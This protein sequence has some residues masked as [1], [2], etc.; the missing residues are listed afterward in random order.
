MS[1][2]RNLALKILIAAG[3]LCLPA[4]ALEVTLRLV[5]AEAPEQPVSS[6]V[7]QIDVDAEREQAQAERDRIAERAK[8]LNL[9]PVKENEAKPKAEFD[10]YVNYMRGILIDGK[11]PFQRTYQ[12]SYLGRSDEIKLSLDDGEHVIDPGA[13]RFT[14]A[15]ATITTTDPTLRV[16]GSRI[17]VLAFPVS[18][19]AVDGSA[20]RALPA[21]LR[22]LPVMPRLYW[23]KED[24]LP[25]EKL[26]ASNA[27]FE[28]LT[29][30]ML[31]N[32]QGAGYRVVPSERNFHVSPDGLTVVDAQGQAVNDRGVSVEDRFTLVLPKVAVPVALHGPRLNVSIAGPSG[33]YK[34]RSEEGGGGRKTPEVFYAFSSPEGARIEFGRRAKNGPVTFH[35][36]LGEF[37]RRR[38]V[39]DARSAESE[40]PRLLS[41][42]LPAGS[43][44]SGQPLRARVQVKDALD[45]PT[46]EPLEVA[47]Y[48]WTRPVLREDGWLGESPSPEVPGEEW[49]RVNVCAASEPEQYDLVMPDLPGNMY[50][51]RIV[52]ARRGEAA[53]QANLSADFLQGIVHPEARLQVSVFCPSGRHAFLRGAEIPISIVLKSAAAIPA[54]KLKLELRRGDRRYTVCERD[55]AAQG[56]G[57]IPFHFV[58]GKQASLALEEGDY[59]LN[60]FV[61]D[62]QS[63]R[64][65]LRIS[66]GRSKRPNPIFLDG[67]FSSLSVD[68]GIEFV[69]VPES[70]AEANA[71]RRIFKRNAEL[72]AR[73][74]DLAIPN[75]Y[76]F[77]PLAKYQGRDSS[78]E[79]AQVEA[80]LRADLSLPAHEVFYYQN[81][82]EAVSEAL[83]FEG[84]GHMSGAVCNY[85][86]IS[87]IH[88]IEKEVRSETR[89][90]QLITQ[91]QDKFEN[92]EGLVPVYPNTDPLGNSEVVDRNRYNRMQ[93]LLKEFNQRHGFDPPHYSDASNYLHAY[94]KDR[95]VPP[96]LAENGRRWEAWMTRTNSLMGEFYKRVRDAVEPLHPGLKLANLGPGWGATGGDSY[97]V[98]YNANQSPVGVWTGFSDFGWQLI[99]EDFLRTRFVRICGNELWG[100]ISNAG[101]TGPQNLKNHV[102]G[103]LASGVQSV[104]YMGMGTGKPEDFRKPFY[105]E[106]LNEIRDLLHTYGPALGAA[107]PLGE[108]GI[109]YPFHQTMY[110]SLAV[111]HPQ[112]LPG[113]GLWCAQACLMQLTSLGFDALFV[114]EEMIDAGEL[115]RFRMLILPSL[116]YAQPKHLEAIA[117]FAEQGKPV[118]TGSLSTLVPPGAVKIE[119]DFSE[120]SIADKRWGLAYPQDDAHAWILAEMSRKLPELKRVLLE[121][122]KPYAEAVTSDTLVQTLAAGDVRYTVVW[123]LRFPSF[124]GTTRIARNHSVSAFYGEANE[125][126]LVPQVARVRLREEG[127]VLY[128]LFSQ[129]PVEVRKAEDGRLEVDCDLS[130][131]PF[132]ILVGLPEPAARWSIERPES[133]AQGLSFPVRFTPLGAQGEPLQAHLPMEV[134]L[135]DAQ[136]GLVRKETGLGS[137]AWS[138]DLPAPLGPQPGKWTLRIKE[139][140]SGR[141][142]QASVEVRAPEGLP[143]AAALIEV[144]AVDIQRRGLIEAFFAVRRTDQAEVWIPLSEGQRGE[145]KAVAEEAREML[146]ILGIRSRLV[147][148][149]DPELYAAGERVHLLEGWTEMNPGSYIEHPLLLLGAE[150]QHKLIEEIQESQLLVRPLTENYPG[151]RRGVLAAVR[152]PFAPDR[153]VVCALGPDPSGVRAALKKLAELGAAPAPLVP[154]PAPVLAAVED[155]GRLEPGSAFERMDGSPVLHVVAPRKDEPLV[156]AS[157]GY[158][159]SFF[160]L[161]ETGAVRAEEK[162]GHCNIE[163]VW[164]VGNAGRIL[165]L[166]EAWM[167]CREPDGSI[168]WRLPIPPQ[169]RKSRCFVDPQGRYVAVPR[170]NGLVI[171][172]FALKELW[173]FD[174]WDSYQSTREILFGRSATCLGLLDEGDTL[175]YRL[176]GRAPGIG[177]RDGDDIVFCD[178]L[179]GSVRKSIPFDAARIEAAAPFERRDAPKLEK[180]T[181]LPAGGALAHIKTRRGHES[182]IMLDA[183]FTPTQIERFQAPTYTGGLSTRSHVTVLPDRSLL[184][185]VG[186]TLCRSD[187]AW[188]SLRVVARPE[189]ICTVAVDL[190]RE[191]LA[192]SD[193]SGELVVL[194]LDL[195]PQWSVPL[196]GAARLAWLPD[197]RLAAGTFRGSAIMLDADGKQLWASDLH[198]FAPPAEVEARWSELE[199]IP[200]PSDAAGALPW[201]D[202]ERQVPLGADLAGLDGAIGAQI[203]QKA[204]LQGKPFGTYLLEWTCTPEQGELSLSLS[205]LEFESVVG[206]GEGLAPEERVSLSAR[207]SGKDSLTQRAIL[208]L[209]DRPD[210]I[211][212]RVAAVGT[213]KAHSRVTIRAL[214]FPSE[215]VVLF[216][217]LYRDQTSIKAQIDPPTK[218]IMAFYN[219][220]ETD[221]PFPAQWLD[222]MCLVNGRAFEREAGLY[223]GKWFGSGDTFKTSS[224]EAI[225]PCAV[226]LELS[227]KR[228]LTHVALAEDPQLS[229]MS[230][231]T[232][233]AFVE[234]RE[235][236][237]DLS[238][239]EKRQLQ[240]GF[241]INL[242]KVRGNAAPYTVIK[243]DKPVYTR[244][245]RVY[246]LEG[247]SSLSEIELYEMPASKLRAG[248]GEESKSK[249]LGND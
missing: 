227:R 238:E 121:K 63:N 242:A 111:S 157:T 83:G 165:V 9:E 59:D 196:G 14:I 245:L 220:K 68:G 104:G 204:E 192:L 202:L 12:G 96:E 18:L 223:A 162:I 229:R 142:A 2:A 24:L 128:D 219:V 175:V 57:R 150:A 37:P 179:T 52:A 90:F 154:P 81:H 249:E 84:M 34:G 194:N 10:K 214:E 152:S 114:T 56:P 78:S 184:F 76:V 51:L 178:A 86:P 46:L 21:E 222:P 3:L 89:K 187:P 147:S 176:E 234:G 5:R 168:A 58:L 247:H 122:F 93:A 248:A 195:A 32:T 130:R 209:G 124:M 26:L 102:A 144:P 169:W 180:L 87:L 206:A 205:A 215:N 160:L 118:F 22:R 243:F 48:V 235:L 7:T 72:L 106:E 155:A 55:V 129:R 172:D 139:L 138:L 67:C 15:G 53:P 109:F 156:F 159:K 1:A 123:N 20:V 4:G 239:Y 97:H 197:G 80:L 40:E 71:A 212:V 79:V 232:V 153:D 30:Y 244:K 82:F 218:S 237:K 33:L 64:W 140:V 120:L 110:E 16:D 193:S 137:P 171:H 49:R 43:A 145:W 148:L 136:G 60:A 143:L 61:G 62:A 91:I 116:H 226:E 29:L 200:G 8:N 39:I 27:T 126:T 44:E 233:D 38:I 221:S 210:R 47:A 182:L 224:N 25:K 103:H 31:A 133:A 166:A 201:T 13:H 19:I 94:L 70:I 131:T 208:K 186:D 191:R 163:G 211:E 216:K 35:G 119:N 125:H 173:R 98:T 158:A 183:A 113:N 170:G 92:F 203:P 117:K 231:F 177:G 95:Q 6:V 207:V 99:Y 100:A 28:R 141:V 185:V 149:A 50:W 230:T 236:R 174:E 101:L 190:E 167:Y 11:H 188:Q 240:R 181:L 66:E 54:G 108:V 127:R 189:G 246:V 161:D 217:A 213:G 228:I 36:D 85:S 199:R 23:N 151:P 45:A 65:S 105:E 146:K 41:V 42:A 112:W 132:R 88:S 75:W 17:D 198:R 73:K 225:V 164:R 241:W 107:K 135:R 69:N 134:E 115:N 74:G 77:N